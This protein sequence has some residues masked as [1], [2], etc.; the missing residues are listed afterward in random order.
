[1][2]M[3]QL[4]WVRSQ[5]FQRHSGIEGRLMKQC[6]IKYKKYIHWR[7]EKYTFCVKII[8]APKK[9]KNWPRPLFMP[10][11]DQACRQKTN[12]SCETVPLGNNDDIALASFLSLP[13][14]PSQ[15]DECSLELMVM[16]FYWARLRKERQRFFCLWNRLQPPSPPLTLP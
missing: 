3:S 2:R 8:R 12:P 16:H 13:I 4:Y 6:W 7:S 14:R 11:N 9:F 5:H 10:R 15:E 1:M